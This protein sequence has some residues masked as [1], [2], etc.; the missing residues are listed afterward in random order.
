MFCCICIFCFLI[1]KRVKAVQ[2]A[3][4]LSGW[5][6]KGINILPIS[7]SKFYKI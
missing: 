1:N 5:G 6:E 2:Q 4:K 7:A 3:L